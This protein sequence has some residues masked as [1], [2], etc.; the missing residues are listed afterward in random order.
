MVVN[1]MKQPEAIR[2]WPLFCKAALDF[3]SHQ[4]SGANALALC[5][6]AASL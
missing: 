4:V 1:R 2:D 3:Y 6:F 5:I